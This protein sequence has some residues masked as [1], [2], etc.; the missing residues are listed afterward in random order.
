MLILERKR[1]LR[2]TCRD[3]AEEKKSQKD[4]S[5]KTLMQAEQSSVA[6]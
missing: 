3:K 2:C 5:R 6:E 1:K 4:V